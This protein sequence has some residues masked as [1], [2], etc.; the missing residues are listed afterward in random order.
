MLTKSQKQEIDELR[1]AFPVL[2]LALKELEDKIKKP[3]GRPKK[4]DAA[5]VETV[6][7]L[8]NDGISIRKIAALLGMSTTTVQTIIKGYR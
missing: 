5:T 3:T 8:K 4:Y 1:A 2:D 6:Q 7:K